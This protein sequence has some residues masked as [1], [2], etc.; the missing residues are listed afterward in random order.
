[1]GIKEREKVV[2]CLWFR[3]GLRREVGYFKMM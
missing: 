2:L 1:M 3:F